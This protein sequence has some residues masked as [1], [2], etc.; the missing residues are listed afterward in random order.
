MDVL[1]WLLRRNVNN[2][3]INVKN[4]NFQE[5]H[6]RIEAIKRSKNVILSDGEDIVGLLS[7]AKKLGPLA[8]VFVMRMV[9]TIEGLRCV[10][11][12]ARPA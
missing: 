7:D 8:A 5:A 11:Q 3:V 6:S 2:I 1:Q 9:I 12:V 10:R 4:V